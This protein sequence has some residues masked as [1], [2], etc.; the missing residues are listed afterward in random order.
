MFGCFSGDSEKVV[1]R[2]YKNLTYAN[3]RIN[4]ANFD[5]VLYYPSPLEFKVTFFGRGYIGK[6]IVGIFEVPVE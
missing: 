6:S 5:T 2:Y 3:F 1:Q 4:F